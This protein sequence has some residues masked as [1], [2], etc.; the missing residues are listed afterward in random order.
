MINIKISF[1]GFIIKLS[2][3]LICSFLLITCSKEIEII[4][5]P[6]TPIYPITINI[7]GEGQVDYE[8][9]NG[10]SSSN[11]ELGTSIILTA[12][13]SENW[14]FIGWSGSIISS[15]NP[16]EITISDSTEVKAKFMRYFDY[17][18]PSNK[19][20]NSDF[21]VDIESIPTSNG[22][23]LFQTSYSAAYSYADFNGDGYEDILLAKN[24]YNIER[25]PLE[26]FINNKNENFVL[27]QTL[28][29]NNIGCETA[30]KSIVGD[31]NG[32]GKPDVFFADH[33]AEGA[34]FEFAYPSILLSNSNGYN[35]EILD[36]LPKSFYHGA[37][38]GDIDNDGDLD[39]ITSTGLV[40]INDGFANFSDMNQLW[41]TSEG[42]I[43]TIELIDINNDG[44]L[45]LIVGGHTMAS[46]DLESEKIYFGNGINYSD[47]NSILLPKVLGYGV[48]TDFSFYDINN[49]GFDDIFVNRA[50]GSVT[51][52]NTYDTD[53]YVGWAVQLIINNQGTDFIDVTD[54]Y[55]DV[56]QGAEN[57]MV[58]IRVQDIDNNGSVDLFENDKYHF[59][60]TQIFRWEWNGSS[61]IKM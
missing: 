58:W 42:G 41:Q 23:D 27:D 33:G 7:E 16:V 4:P 35:F 6:E 19:F 37:A 24:K 55:F 54:S 11:Y 56:F 29:Q 47:S 30:R 21:W 39:I 26:L 40:L 53:F 43:Y 31:Y 32:D 44:F 61:F 20:K 15:E 14:E 9:I 10:I 60:T 48:S 45:D 34:V 5:E 57:S 36:N 25:H 8:S 22:I 3:L 17:K 52:N 59:D 28:I 49:D 50:G 18:Q 51:A 2:A 12:N 1:N 46:Y 38:S 13:P